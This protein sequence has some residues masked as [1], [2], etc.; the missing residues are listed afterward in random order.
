MPVLNDVLHVRAAVTSLLG[1]DYTGPFDVTLA[2]APSIDGTEELVAELAELDPRIRV[3]PNEIG[4]T[5]AGLNA[6][7]RASA[8]PVVIRVDAH[9]VL[10]SDYARVAVD[11]LERTGADNVGGVMDARGTAP[12]QRAVARAY[13]TRIGLGGTPLHVGGPEGA[14]ETVY[15]GCFRR[16]SLL[17]AGLFDET[18]KRGQ[19]WELNRRLRE[20]GG[21][22]WFT[23]RLRVVYR[24]RPSLSRL[25]RQMLST[26]MWRGELARRFP[27]D[28][29]IRY[30]VPPVMVLL[31][32]AGVVLGFAGV[33][34]PWLL[35]GWIAP[36]GYL[37]VVL[38]ATVVVTRPDG[39]RS[40]AW[41][42]LVLPC[43]HFCWGF[44]FLLGY[45]KL[46]SNIAARTG[47]HL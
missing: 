20:Q 18:I 4:S 28:N 6:A 26:G 19:D 41:F 33:V 14:A 27:A 30:F 32:T 24:P 21:T 23:P 45:L 42:L 2:L 37:L 44:G 16:D 31:V 25:A 17:R 47:R 46:T 29:G 22:V 9:S 1:Q 12:F 3:V 10:P 15:L 39:G 7:I 35:L 34:V 13:G 38:L 36:V 40:G 5:P 8:Y 43:I 11:T